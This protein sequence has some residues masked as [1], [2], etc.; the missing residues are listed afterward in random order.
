MLG[1]PGET[2]ADIRETVQHL[3][4]ANPDLF[5]IRVAYPIKGT[6][7]YEE[8]EA[9]SPEYSGSELP[10]EQ[11]TD[12]DLDFPRTYPRRYYDFAVRWTVNSVH[13]YKARL[14]GKSLTFKGLKLL[15]KVSAARAGM[16]ASRF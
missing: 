14:A 9:S 12:R 10:W 8:V 1:C 6:G 3:K 2:E 11:R 5:T 16:W 4:A 15:G 13:L 7:L